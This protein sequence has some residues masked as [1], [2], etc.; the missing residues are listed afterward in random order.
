MQILLILHISVCI[1]SLI[2][3]TS[4]LLFFFSL[5]SISMIKAT[6]FELPD[7]LQIFINTT[8]SLRERN[9]PTKRT[10]G[11]EFS[12]NDCFKVKNAYLPLKMHI[13]QRL[14]LSSSTNLHL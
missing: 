5:Y 2:E 14:I 1:L 10:I 11:I 9:F 4:E 6:Y 8:F 3:G 13:K 7:L 12:S